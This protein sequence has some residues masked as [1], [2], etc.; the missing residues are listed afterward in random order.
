VLRRWRVTDADL[1]QPLLKRSVGTSILAPDPIAGASACDVGA[2]LIACIVTTPNTN[3]TIM[4]TP[5]SWE[6]QTSD[7][8]VEAGGRPCRKLARR[9]RVGVVRPLMD[10]QGDQCT[11]SDR[12]VVLGTGAFDLGGCGT[13]V[14][15]VVGSPA[16]GAAIL[17]CMVGGP[18]HVRQSW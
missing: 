7:S 10:R 12:V 9:C 6:C 13:H 2:P 18:V 16:G 14:C 8:V 15:H 1:F 5:E 11:D 3:A 17:L 4:S